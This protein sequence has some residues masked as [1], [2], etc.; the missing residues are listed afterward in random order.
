MS[1]PSA[2]TDLRGVLLQAVSVAIAA[3]WLGEGYLSASATSNDR[4]Q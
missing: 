2:L 3:A 4:D 1:E